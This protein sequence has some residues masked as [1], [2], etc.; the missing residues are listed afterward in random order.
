MK[1]I[2]FSIFALSAIWACNK[3]EIAPSEEIAS[4][5]EKQTIYATAVVSDDADATKLAYNE[6]QPGGGM[7]MKST[8]EAG[9]SFLALQDS[10]T[11]VTF[12]LTSGEGTSNGVFSAEATGVTAATQWIAVLGNAAVEQG[13]GTE[14]HCSFMNQKGTKATLDDFN[15]VKADGTG[16]NPSFNFSTGDKLAHVLR[17]KLPAGIKCIEYTPCAWNKV[18]GT[19][20]KKVY[21]NTTDKDGAN[22]YGPSKTSTIT[23]DAESKAGDCIYLAIPCVD[24]SRTYMTY[25]SGKQNMNL[26]NGIVLTIMNNNSDNATKSTGYVYEQNAVNEGGKIQTVDMSGM[27]LI[28]RPKPADAVNIAKT[29]VVCVA[30]SS[31]LKQ[32]GDVNTYWAPFNLGASKVSEAGKYIAFGEY[33]DNGVY[34]YV[35]YTLRHKPTGTMYDDIICALR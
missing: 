1:K 28:S 33:Y 25:N 18:T 22:D 35:T 21:Y 23:L 5:G 34:D 19:E 14:I 10:N 24:Y 26:Q 12:T 17:V 13:S 3:Q 9:D 6:I 32:A 15:Y 29:G 27:T 20:V 7:G 31:A 8:W 2:I 16:E 11:V 30:H 4:T